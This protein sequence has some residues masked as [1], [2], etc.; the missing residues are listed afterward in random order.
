M[1]DLPGGARIPVTFKPGQPLTAEELNAMQK[2]L[3]LLLL[4][5]DH[6]GND[7]ASPRGVPIDWQG[8]AP[9]AVRGQHIS[10]NAVAKGD[11]HNGAVG[12]SE[13][14]E[15]CIGSNHLVDEAVGTPQIKEKAVTL[16]KLADEVLA[17]LNAPRE[18]ATTY[19]YCTWL[20]GLIAYPTPDRPWFDWLLDEAAPVRVHDLPIRR[21]RDDGGWQP[22]RSI[23]PPDAVRPIIPNL[24]LATRAEMA[25]S[26]AGFFKQNEPVVREVLGGAVAE[27]RSEGS[28]WGVT[29]ASGER[30][31][32]ADAEMKELLGRLG[33][34]GADLT[35]L[36]NPLRTESFNLIGAFERAA[37][38]RTAPIYAEPIRTAPI[39]RQPI[40]TAPIILEPIGTTPIHRLPFDPSL[41]LNPHPSDDL[42]E[43]HRIGMLVDPASIGWK[44]AR[45]GTALY[46]PGVGGNAV[47]SDS[48]QPVTF[49]PHKNPSKEELLVLSR[50]LYHFGIENDERLHPDYLLKIPKIYDFLNNPHLLAAGYWTGGSRNIR[51]VIRMRHRGR[52]FVRVRFATPYTDTSYTVSITPDYLFE[53]EEAQPPLIPQVLHRRAE[54]VDLLFFRGSDLVNKLSFSIAIHGELVAS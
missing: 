30:L 45:E 27:V 22:I 14:Q 46:Q 34:A 53:E 5:H 25:V 7:Q 43:R 28:H 48:G 31:S 52:E 6:T 33:A 29:L 20:D 42:Q 41:F 18:G 40:R 44:G 50:I 16:A 15:K 3:L 9:N 39:R 37:P 19:G 36:N 35:R 38:I 24:D 4:T 11:I 47:F 21:L 1:S 49:S 54:Y 13:I 32:L 26:L 51:S 2:E 12:A 17:L 8:L 23:L 10:P